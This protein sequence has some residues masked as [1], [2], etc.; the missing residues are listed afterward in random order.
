MMENQQVTLSQRLIDAALAWLRVM[1]LGVK[2]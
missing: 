1:A 2:I